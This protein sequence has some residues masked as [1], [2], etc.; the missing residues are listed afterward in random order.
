MRKL[1]TNIGGIEAGE[2]MADYP[3][4]KTLLP[5]K[6]DFKETATIGTFVSII[7]GEIVPFEAD[8]MRGVLCLDYGTCNPYNCKEYATSLNV[9]FS[10]TFGA[11]IKAGEVLKVGD[12]FDIEVDTGLVKAGGLGSGEGIII[13]IQGDVAI[14]HYTH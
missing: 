1:N 8:T 11:K 2:T 4:N 7:D 10:G 3:F 6:D 5:V 14:T 13:A 9:G 12:S